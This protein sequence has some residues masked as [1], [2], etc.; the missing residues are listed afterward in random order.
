MSSI[1]S[2]AY[3]V[4]RSCL[5]AVTNVP[6]LRYSF[7]YSDGSRSEAFLA[8]NQETLAVLPTYA[9]RTDFLDTLMRFD[10]V[11]VMKAGSKL[12]EIAALLKEVGRLSETWIIQNLGFDDEVIDLLGASPFLRRHALFTTLIVRRKELLTT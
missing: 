6:R 8:E 5:I 4:L 1:Y 11:V 3:Y 7:L 2:T 12:N 10:T 9:N